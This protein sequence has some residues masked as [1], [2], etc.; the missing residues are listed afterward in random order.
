M[1]STRDIV[2]I[3]GSNGRI[4]SAVTKRLSERFD[5]VVGLDREAPVLSQSF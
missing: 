2:L 3:T 4:G 1:K 5:N